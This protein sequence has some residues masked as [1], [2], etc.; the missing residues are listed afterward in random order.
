LQPFA[1]IARH[2]EPKG[3]FQVYQKDVINYYLSLKAQPIRVFRE[4]DKS[5]L[6]E[7]PYFDYRVESCQNGSM[8]VFDREGMM[9]HIKKIDKFIEIDVN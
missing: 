2:S 7:I 8:N 9:E 6:I 4:N 3:L 1:F 5:E